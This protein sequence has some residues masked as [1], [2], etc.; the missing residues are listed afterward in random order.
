MFKV[1]NLINLLVPTFDPLCRL[2]VK[3]PEESLWPSLAL[4][5]YTH[6][7]TFTGFISRCIAETLELSNP[8]LLPYTDCLQFYESIKEYK[9]LQEKMSKQQSDLRRLLKDKYT[10]I[11]FVVI[12]PEVV[13]EL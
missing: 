5:F 6:I 12:E 13:E 11:Q 8:L 3:Y 1:F 10:A 4:Q 2:H 9:I 7:L